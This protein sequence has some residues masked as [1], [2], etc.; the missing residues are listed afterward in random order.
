MK[1]VKTNYSNLNQ[2]TFIE[3]VLYVIFCLTNNLNFPDLHYT[4]AQ[5]NTKLNAYI[6]A[7][8]KSVKGDHESTKLAAKIRTELE[9]MLKKNAVY[10]NFTA[11]GDEVMLVS[12]GFNLAKIGKREKRPPISV[13]PTSLSKQVKVVL[14]FVEHAVSYLVF[15]CQTNEPDPT[16]EKK[17][18]RQKG[19]TKTYQFINGIDPLKQY[20]LMFSSI[21]KDG[22]SEMSE[23]FPFM[24][25]K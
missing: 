7:L 10:V 14:N 5:I 2:P 6:E 12:S 21:S 13:F 16:D 18:S 19:T 4:A 9:L 1:K 20:Y 8:N 17:W 22:E 15:I 11:E 3:F 24:I 23:P 25:L